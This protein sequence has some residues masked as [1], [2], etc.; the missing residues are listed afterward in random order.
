MRQIDAEFVEKMP[1]LQTFP[2]KAKITFN[3]YNKQKRL[4][5]SNFPRRHLGFYDVIKSK[6]AAG[7]LFKSNN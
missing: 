7:G 4:S 3:N 1:K 2:D 5:L 6:M